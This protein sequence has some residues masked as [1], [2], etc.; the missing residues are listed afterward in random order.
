MPH[1]C[2]SGYLEIPLYVLLHSLGFQELYSIGSFSYR[3]NLYEERRVC[4]IGFFFYRGV[5]KFRSIST[6]AMATE[7]IADEEEEKEDFSEGLPNSLYRRIKIFGDP[8]HS[9]VAALE[10]WIKEGKKHP[11]K[12]EIKWMVKE[13]RKYSRH[14]HALEIFEWMGQKFSF[15]SGECAIHLDLIEKVC[16]IASA[17]KYFTDLPYTEKNIQTYSVLLNCYVKE[18]NKI[19][20]SKA[21]MEKLKFLGFA[22]DPVPYTEMMTLYMNTKKFEKVPLVIQEMKKNDISLNTLCYNIWMKSYATLLDMDQVEEVLNEI[23][24]GDNIDANWTVYGTRVDI[25]MKAKV[26]NKAQSSLKEMESKMKEMEAKK[27]QKEQA[28]YDCLIS[29]HG[30][31]GNKDEIYRIWQSFELTLPETTYRSHI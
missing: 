17:E 7:K 24:R 22:K 29:L 11:K 1:S 26:L 14:Q 31:L 8:K 28:A 25:Y 3:D 4:K 2:H 23:E 16:G 15:S 12:R 18:K 13:L 9:V 10:G 20:K 5:C 19:K 27:K 30:N 6:E 21:T